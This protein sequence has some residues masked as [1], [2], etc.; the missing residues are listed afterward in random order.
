MSG[1]EILEDVD[2][3]VLASTRTPQAALGKE[4]AGRVAQLYVVGDALA[5]R[6]LRSATYEGHRFARMVGEENVP[7]TTGEALFEPPDRDAF[8]GLMP[9]GSLHRA[10]AG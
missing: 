8:E 3:V 9:A 10:V 5:P 6:D 7:R 2:A 4:L 1:T